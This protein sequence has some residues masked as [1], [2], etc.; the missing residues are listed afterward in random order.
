MHC[1]CVRAWTCITH[2]VGTYI[3]LHSHMVETH[4][5]FGGQNA[6]SSHVNHETLGG[7]LGLRLD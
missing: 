4:L 6:G 7:T 2:V 1:V 3:C 5:P